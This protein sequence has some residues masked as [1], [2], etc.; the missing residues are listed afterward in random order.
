MRVDRKRSRLRGVD[1]SID[2]PSTASTVKFMGDPWDLR[3]EID[4]SGGVG[5]T[6]LTIL[7]EFPNLGLPKMVGFS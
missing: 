4:G 3:K 7:W 2:W 1:R 5:W 6:V